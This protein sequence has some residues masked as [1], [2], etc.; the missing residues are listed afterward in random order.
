MSSGA[1]DKTCIASP[2]ILAT[3]AS[4]ALVKDAE[5][6]MLKFVNAGTGNDPFPDVNAND[7]S[8]GCGRQ[9]AGRR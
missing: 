1:P 8:M 7:A 5:L 3:V 2:M 9:I 4:C 6:L